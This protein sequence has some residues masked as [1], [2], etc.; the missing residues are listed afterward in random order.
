[1]CIVI[2]TLTPQEPEDVRAPL[3]LRPCTNTFDAALPGDLRRYVYGRALT[4]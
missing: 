2:E 3:A 1:M 4:D